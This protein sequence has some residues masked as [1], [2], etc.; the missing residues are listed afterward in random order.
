MDKKVKFDDL[1][2]IAK[3]MIENDITEDKVRQYLNGIKIYGYIS[4]AKKFEYAEMINA[5]DLFADTA[6]F[7]SSYIAAKLEV[8]RKML[9]I[10][11]YT[12]VDVDNEDMTFENYDILMASGLYDVLA[13]PFKKDYVRLYDI[14]KDSI[15]IR[16]MTDVNSML[17]SY[18]HKQVKK[19]IKE[20]NKL[21]TE[22]EG[23]RN[24]IELLK[25]NNP[26]V[27]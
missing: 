27:K 21:L 17:A 12:N 19:D 5:M 16:N 20:I 3:S 25:F 13:E 10:R 7:P 1:L 9:A 24:L 6:E 11:Y 14:T 26:S 18:N 22:S 23:Y 2:A 4:V 15:S 8:I